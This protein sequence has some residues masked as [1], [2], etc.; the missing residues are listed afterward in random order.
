VSKSY[1]RIV[2]DTMH[3]G[4]RQATLWGLEC[5]VRRV[6]GRVD[7]TKLHQALRSLEEAGRIE[8]VPDAPTATYR[9]RPGRR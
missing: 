9:F 5:A 8:R 4:G 2:T 3:E 1:P 6:K 7:G